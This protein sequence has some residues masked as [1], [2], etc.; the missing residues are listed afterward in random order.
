VTV[1]GMGYF[2]I[3]TSKLDDWSILSILRQKIVG[4]IS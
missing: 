2:W 4:Q 3:G 1:Q